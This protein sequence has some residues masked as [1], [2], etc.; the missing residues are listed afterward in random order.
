MQSGV[1][2]QR[3]GFLVGY[4]VLAALILS[5]SCIAGCLFYTWGKRPIWRLSTIERASKVHF[6]P[7][8]RLL[9]GEAEGIFRIKATVSIP[10]AS[11]EKFLSQPRFQKVE[12]EQGLIRASGSEAWIWVRAEIP[13]TNSAKAEV[14]FAWNGE[15]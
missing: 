6:P 3:I 15:D 12:R 4:G 5:Y 13:D 2:R 1:R 8:S 10:R 14:R 11:V 7:G 9:T